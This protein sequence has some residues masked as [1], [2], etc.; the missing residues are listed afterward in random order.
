MKKGQFVLWHW[1]SAK[2]KK[3]TESYVNRISGSKVNL[4]RFQGARYG[5]VWVDLSDIEWEI[6]EDEST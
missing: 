3:W 6:L 5:G 2:D 1:H 4:I